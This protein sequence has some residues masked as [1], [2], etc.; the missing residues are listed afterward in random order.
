MR[1]LFTH[2]SPA[3]PRPSLHR[4]LWLARPLSLRL[5]WTRRQTPPTKP[6][7]SAAVCSVTVG[8]RSTPFAPSS[9]PSLLSGDNVFE[10]D[11]LSPVVQTDRTCSP[12]SSHP[13]SARSECEM[14]FLGIRAS[15]A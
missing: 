1:F 8:N 9:P 7:S 11:E 2:T 14:R 5:P 15:V 12:R 6:A 4:R 3:K 13:D 10:V